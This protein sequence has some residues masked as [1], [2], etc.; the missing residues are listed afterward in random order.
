M[1]LWVGLYSDWETCVK[2]F[3]FFVDMKDFSSGEENPR[4]YT[5]LVKKSGA[6]TYL[7]RDKKQELEKGVLIILNEEYLFKEDYEFLLEIVSH[8]SSHATDAIWQ[9]IGGEYHDFD[10]GDEP[11]A[12]LLG[13]VAG[14]IG[15]YLSEYFKTIKDE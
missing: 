4:V 2:K 9:H 5:S 15:G 13:W 14:K 6:V 8:E 7:V 12:Y 1:L 11:R 10:D 3:N